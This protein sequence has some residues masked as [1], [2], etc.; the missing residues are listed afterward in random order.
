MV[1]RG[2]KSS[3]QDGS[4]ARSERVRSA[5]GRKLSSTRWLQRQ[6]NDP[7]VQAAQRV[8]YRSRAAYKL[9]QIDERF[10]FL[11]PG[12]RVVDLGAAPGGWTQVVVAQVKSQETAG[13][14]VAI[15]ILE[16]EPLAGAE[17]LVG[18][19]EDEA[20]VARLRTAIG[21]P[22]DV[23][24]SDMAVPTTGHAST[25]HLRTLALAEA[26]FLFA[27]EV[28]SPGG[29]FVTKVFQGVDEPALFDAM[30]QRFSSVRRFKPKASRSDSVELFLVGTGFKNA[31]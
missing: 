3:G 7:Y 12:R 19:I 17:I 14:V 5:R 30:R 8:G 6:L 22:V 21:D 16:M 13:Q 29:A 28:L 20:A 2:R 4:R 9:L 15:D 18:D 23:V 24:L 25:D 11:Q 26:A 31:D 1:A 27:C 10:E